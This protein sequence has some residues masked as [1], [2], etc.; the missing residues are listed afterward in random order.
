[1]IM[2]PMFPLGDLNVA[3]WTTGAAAEV[4]VDAV[5]VVVVVGVEAVD[6]PFVLLS[7]VIGGP[8]FDGVD[9]LVT[10]TVCV[11]LEPQPTTSSAHTTANNGGPQV[12]TR[13]EAYRDRV[14]ATSSCV[15]AVG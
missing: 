11:P 8:L 4:G 10:V 15:I 6:P 1:M 13:A 9:V 2:Q 5:V 7:V 3:R 12:F 14:A